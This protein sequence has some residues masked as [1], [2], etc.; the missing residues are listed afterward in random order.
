MPRLAGWPPTDELWGWGMG[1]ESPSWQYRPPPIAAT[2]D[3]T[4]VPDRL[5]PSW[6]AEECHQLQQLMSDS[7]GWGHCMGGVRHLQYMRISRLLGSRPG[8][9]ATTDGTSDGMST[10][11]EANYWRE[12]PV[13]IC[14]WCSSSNFEIHNQT[15]II[16]AFPVDIHRVLWPLEHLLAL[17]R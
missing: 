6:S 1:I 16:L 5:E 10:C 9:V 4:I 11:L 2:W 14:K 13:A 3:V 7:L 12:V 15:A 17:T 8:G